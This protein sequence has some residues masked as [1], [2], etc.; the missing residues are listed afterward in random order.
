MRSVRW[1]RPCLPFT[2]VIA[3]V[4]AVGRSSGDH[5]KGD[6]VGMRVVLTALFLVLVVGCGGDGSPGGTGGEGGTGGATRWRVIPSSTTKPLYG[7][8]ANGAND[9]YAVGGDAT[10][11]LV[12]HWDGS[13]W[14]NT[15]YPT[16]ALP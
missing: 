14:S 3:T 1:F 10:G 8:W 16:M 4:L 15:G 11:N 6:Q 7:I 2:C 13:T 12:L 5:E 9:A